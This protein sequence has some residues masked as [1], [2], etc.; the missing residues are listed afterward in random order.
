MLF[1]DPARRRPH[2]IA[3][4]TSI[5]ISISAG[6]FGFLSSF[7]GITMRP[8]PWADIIHDGI[9]T[10]LNT[11]PFVFWIAFLHQLLYLNV[12]KTPAVLDFERRVRQAE[13]LFKHKRISR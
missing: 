11:I 7:I 1:V 5:V 9:I 8:R 3:L 12:R 10:G 4:V 13:D 6:G 2:L